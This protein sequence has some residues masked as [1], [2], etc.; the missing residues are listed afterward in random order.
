MDVTGEFDLLALSWSPQDNSEFHLLTWSSAEPT[1]PSSK[2]ALYLPNANPPARK[3]VSLS[4]NTLHTLARGKI[5]TAV[6]EGGLGLVPLLQCA[7]VL[8]LDFLLCS[9]LWS[10]EGSVLPICCPSQTSIAH[11]GSW[12]VLALS[13]MLLFH[14]TSSLIVTDF[15]DVMTELVRGQLFRSHFERSVLV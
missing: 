3:D 11:F 8:L 1:L 6:E 12:M 15:Q 5:F 9:I 10:G 14:E 13:C 7:M 4:R 2:P